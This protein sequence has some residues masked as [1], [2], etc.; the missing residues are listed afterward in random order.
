MHAGRATALKR[1]RFEPSR[2]RAGALDERLKLRIL[3]TLLP[4]LAAGFLPNSGRRRGGDHDQLAS[5]DIFEGSIILLFRLLFLLHAEARGLP[6]NRATPDGGDR[7]QTIAAEIAAAAGN[8]QQ[9]VARRI[10][11]AYSASRTTLSE[12]L[13]SLFRIIPASTGDRL[14][15]IDQFLFQHAVSDRALALAIDGLARDVDKT[16]VLATLDYRSLDVRHLGSIYES[17]LEH[18]LVA[19]GAARRVRLARD[20]TRRRAT[21]SF[22]TPP[23][24]VA[25]IIEQTVGAVLD[26]KLAALRPEFRAAC[27]GRGL[28][29]R[30]LFER[31]L[32]VRVLDAA[33]GTGNFLLA[34]VECISQRVASFLAEFPAAFVDEILG[35]KAG[36]SPAS[37]D[38][39]QLKRLVLTRCVYGV[40]LD[41]LAV[42]LARFCLWLDG[43]SGEAPLPALD[44]LRCGNAL[45][46]A[47]WHDLP[48]GAVTALLGSE[49]SMPDR[50][51]NLRIIFDLLTASHF[52]L[53]EAAQAG[54]EI[55]ALRS[56]SAT[57]RLTAWKARGHASLVETVRSLAV[58]PD[59]RFFHW[60]LEFP[61]VFFDFAADA[62]GPL[63]HKSARSAGSAGFDAVVGN[64]PYV[65]SETM[66]RHHGRLRTACAR[67]LPA[68]RGNWDLFCAFIDRG[69]S[70]LN[71]RGI[72]SQIVPNK[73]LA[74]EYAA[75]IQRRIGEHTLLA[76]RDYSRASV[77]EDAGVYP[78]VPLIAKRRTAGDIEIQIMA[79]SDPAALRVERQWRVPRA[80][81]AS[82]PPGCWSP[83]VSRDWELLERILGNS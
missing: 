10:G 83:I 18:T 5:Q 75:A 28:P 40:D 55:G 69:L 62:P 59:V 60:E 42:E 54:Q 6:P 81:L 3:R 38:C 30:E 34:A 19:S 51:A 36:G 26:A 77:F 82:L 71:E 80:R 8:D 78:L 50:L 20:T 22:Y 31:L 49:G 41:P 35:A 66:T 7:L 57:R 74:A 56:V 73:L 47:G 13:D 21:G 52:D 53:P 67:M 17:L 33:M 9:Q 15:H 1:S 65:D 64:P 23:A 63:R 79:G 48:D 76:I 39:S 25:H 44:H 2:A 61:E 11:E 29:A 24:I 37:D 16:G 27:E 4:E 32:D 70:L 72:W 58:Q 12:R 45:V 68:C 46:G 43:C 14:L